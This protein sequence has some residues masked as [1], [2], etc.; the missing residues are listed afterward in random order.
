VPLSTLYTWRYHGDGPPGFR[1]G[2][3]IRYRWT[4]VQEWV[5]D[6]LRNNK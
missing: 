4:D 3:H 5:K 1:V 6:Q 2:K